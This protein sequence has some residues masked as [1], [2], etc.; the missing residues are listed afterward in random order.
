VAVLTGATSKFLTNG[1][2]LRNY[3]TLTYN[4]GTFSL[5]T[6]TAILNE[7]G[8][9][10][11]IAGNLN[12]ATTGGTGQSL[13]NNGTWL[14]SAGGGISSTPFSLTNNGLTLVSF[15]TLQF[16]GGA[17][18]NDTIEVALGAVMDLNGVADH[19]AGAVLRGNGTFDVQ[20]VTAGVFD[21]IVAPGTSAGTL[22][23]LGDYEPDLG[24]TLVMELE[25]STAG[26]FDL[27]QISAQTTGLNTFA[28]NLA[29]DTLNNFVPSLGD[30]F[31]ILTFELRTSGFSSVTFPDVLGTAFDTVFTT[32]QS[33]DT[34]Y[35][36][37]TSTAPSTT[38]II[39]AGTTSTDWDDPS[40]WDTGAVPTSLDNIYIPAGSP[41][42]PTTTGNAS[43]ADLV[44]AEGAT[45]TVNS[46]DVLNVDGDMLAGFT[47][48]AGTGSVLLSSGLGRL[49]GA[50]P[51]VEITG[52]YI[53]TDSVF[54]NGNLL[55]SGTGDLSAGGQHID[56]FGDLTTAGS[57]TLTMTDIADTV[58]VIG[59]ATFGGAGTNTLLTAGRLAV[60][61]NF[62][63]T[64]P[65]T[66]AFSPSGTHRVE[67]NGTGVQTVTFATPGT[68]GAQSH[69]NQL[70][71][72][73]S[74]GSVDLA[75]DVFVID[76]L[77]SIGPTTT[78]RN[79][80]AGSMIAAGVNVD[81]MVLDNVKFTID[82][83]KIGAFDAVTFQNYATTATQ[84]TVIHPGATA[85]TFTF[86]SL[87][88]VPLNVGDTGFY[89][90]AIDDGA[91]PTL[92]LDIAGSN[93]TANGPTFTT[94]SGGADVTWTP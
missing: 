50:V 29:I 43:T 8:A 35:V 65:A 37:V 83:T 26:T 64:S 33:P 75:G 51:S 62:T 39:W 17:V 31:P 23:W 80:G 4:Q 20:D 3:G 61:G 55:I 27:L 56:V 66:A 52:T 74:S 5:G 21:G 82:G 1:R 38:D 13:T 40:N 70:E 85:T 59:N 10:F 34:M 12:V 45:V 73:K 90:A 87:T 22:T 69:F 77:V 30:A 78:V 81:G 24:S 7:V 2:T 86:N 19:N 67:L 91:A 36:V 28:G 92:F 16:A 84:L 72:N 47:S 32:G 49:A 15:G 46:P 25:G 94:T 14:K 93:V 54:V 42:D 63:Q 6:N 68:A 53:A 60:K 44:I 71:L 79:A 11:D 18:N 58:S 41:N 89:L 57:G 48:V 9:V 88:F 76:Q